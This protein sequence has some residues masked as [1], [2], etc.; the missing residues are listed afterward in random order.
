[1]D[2]TLMGQR[3]WLDALLNNASDTSSLANLI[4]SL[5]GRSPS[6]L[7]GV[8]RSPSS[9]GVIG[10][11]MSRLGMGD[12]S[13]QLLNTLGGRGWSAMMDTL[14]RSDMQGI[15]GR[16]IDVL[17]EELAGGGT[18]ATGGA[19]GNSGSTRQTGRNDQ[20]E[21]WAN[22]GGGVDMGGGVAGDAGSAGLPSWITNITDPQ[23]RAMMELAYN[24]MNPTQ[25][26]AFAD[27][28]PGFILDYIDSWMEEI[29]PGNENGAGGIMPHLT[30]ETQVIQDYTRSPYQNTG[31]GGG[32]DTGRGR[33]PRNNGGRSGGG[34]GGGGRTPQG[35]NVTGQVSPFGGAFAGSDQGGQDNQFVGGGYAIPGQIDRALR[36]RDREN[37]RADREVRTNWGDLNSRRTGGSGEREAVRTS[38]NGRRVRY[39]D[40]TVERQGKERTRER[41]RTGPAG[42]TTNVTITRNGGTAISNQSGGN[43]NRDGGGG[44]NRNRDQQRV[45]EQAQR[46]S[47]QQQRGND[48]ER[49][50]KRK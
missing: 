39:S 6:A 18:G 19:A 15:M 38:D 13:D 49:K 30:P 8:G 16:W 40:G 10:R 25:Q 43:N 7:G 34:T 21:T 47:R 2:N 33:G 46:A 9:L 48:E 50:R 28:P 5:S 41:S 17:G 35:I 20:K 4:G 1:M 22:N 31:P 14:G 11:P 26:A 45:V 37:R 36:E 23:L 12:T 44:G 29:T 27:N 24:Q 42:T 32:R 3:S